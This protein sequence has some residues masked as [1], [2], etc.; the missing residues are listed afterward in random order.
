MSE[1]WQQLRVLIVGAGSIGKRHGRVLRA[2]GVDHITLCDPSDHQ[3][4]SALNDVR[5]DEVVHSLEEGLS[6]HPEAVLICTPPELHVSQARQALQAGCH[7]FTEK[8]ISDRVDGIPELDRLIAESG[9][10][11]MVGLCFRYHAGI[12]KA[13]RMVDEGQ[14]GRLVSIRAL[15]GEHLPEVRPDYRNLSIVHGI[16]AFDL[17]HDIDLAIWFAS[18]PIEKVLCVHGSYSDIGIGGPDVVEMLLD[19]ENKCVANVHLDFFQRPRRRQI[20]LIGTEG[21]ITVDFSR[22]DTCTISRYDIAAQSWTAETLTT[23]RDDMFRAEDREFLEAIAFNLPVKCTL[24]EGC[25]SLRAVLAA[26]TDP[27]YCQE[28]LEELNCLS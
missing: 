23:D 20:D 3:L 17:M 15:V 14:I 28:K 9:R 8:P 12:V 6:R 16:G 22:W 18:Q 11:F 26:M 10:K 24:R 19:F 2:L 7:V 5:A 1:L 4:D 25:G 21:T 13:K 27:T